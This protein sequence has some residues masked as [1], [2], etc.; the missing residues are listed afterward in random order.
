V[1]IA[2]LCAALGRWL[3][4]EKRMQRIDLSKVQDSTLTVRGTRKNK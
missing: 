1:T 2:D 4:N 3:D